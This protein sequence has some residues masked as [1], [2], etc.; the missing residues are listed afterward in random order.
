M[1][2]RLGAENDVH[3]FGAD[4]PRVAVEIHRV[5]NLVSEVA[6]R[7]RS[8]RCPGSGR[9]ARGAVDRAARRTRRRGRGP[10]PSAS[11]PARSRQMLPAWR[12]NSRRSAASRRRTAVVGGAWSGGRQLSCVAVAKL[13]LFARLSAT[14]APVLGE[15]SGRSRSHDASSVK[16]S[17]K[18]AGRAPAEPVADLRA[19]GNPPVGVP[20]P[21]RPSMPQLGACVD[22]EHV[23]GD[24]RP[25]RRRSSA[26]RSRRCRSPRAPNA[27]SSRQGDT[28]R[29][30]PRST[31]SH[32][33]CR[34]R[35]V[36]GTCREAPRPREREPGDSGP[37]TGRT[38]ST[39][40]AC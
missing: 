21:S 24:R 33:P 39:G 31:R 25:P 17:L 28:R 32:A 8:C 29:R 2:E 19:V 7:R 40:A 6:L 35:R 34:V 37:P 5:R 23:A 16:P 3:G 14:K 10:R 11:S 38:S 36:V 22:A 15:D 30:R 26:S 13:V 1:L 27:A 20:A 12:S 4:G 9:R 18:L